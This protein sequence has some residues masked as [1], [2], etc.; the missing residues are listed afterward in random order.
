MA[1]SMTDQIIIY[2]SPDGAAHIAV[3]LEAETVWLTQK[4]MSE[5]FGKNVRTVNEHIRN[6]FREAELEEK[7]VIR[8]FRITA[9]DGKI[10]DISHYNLDVIISVGYRVKSQRG[11]QFRQWATK[12]L[13]DHLVQGFTVNQARIAE[14]GLS[15]MQQA[16]ELL[17]RTLSNQTLVTEMGKDVL[18]VIV[19]YARTWRLLLQ[20]DEDALVLPS[21]CQPA[22]GV[23]EYDFAT[24]AITELK[25]ELMRQ[26]EATGLF[27]AEQGNALAAILGNIEQTMFGKPLY[28]TREE[29]AAHLLYF[30]IKD[31]PFVD[32][33]KRIGS[34]LFLL[35]NRQEGIPGVISENTL[36]ALALLIAESE[37]SNKDLMIRLVVNLLIP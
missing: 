27:G 32:G 10:Y 19:G 34:F 5:L 37:P 20:Y 15:E 9:T 4:Q 30:V 36:T 13:R 23:L 2:Q 1:Y 21:G 18:S 26:D 29:K 14:K 11:T 31:H 3:H 7:S 8:K 33:N 25:R 22:R 6:I 12:V 16:V 28:K 17:A 35:Y 24:Q